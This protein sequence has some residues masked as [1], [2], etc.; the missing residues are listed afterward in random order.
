MREQ[1]S[2]AQTVLITGA[3]GG[4]GREFAV[5]FAQHGDNLALVS[6]NREQLLALGQEL[7]ARHGVGIT[8]LPYDLAE[9]DAPPR[10]LDELRQRD[11][12]VDTLINNA[13]FGAYGAFDE[14][15]LTTLLQMLQVNITAL[16]HLARLLLPGMLARDAGKILNV[17][18]TAAFYPGPLMAV[19]YASKAY[20]LS[21]SEALAGEVQGTGVTVSV[22]CPGATRTGFQRR[23]RLEGSRVSRFDV[24]EPAAVARAGYRGLQAGHTVIIP[25]IL[26]KLVA[27]VPRLLPRGVLTRLVRAVQEQAEDDTASAS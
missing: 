18:S 23:A 14:M 1:E 25:G 20:V 17:A 26:N 7:H 15:E 24:M 13:G 4:I 2:R 3:S 10:L 16:T 8:V 6:R 19:Y 22:L 27:E 12:T 11:I 21:F 5:L 9:P